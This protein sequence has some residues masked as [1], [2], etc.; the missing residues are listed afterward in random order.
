MADHRSEQI[1][2]AYMAR[3]MGLTTT[4]LNV[5]RDR[6]Y[7]VSNATSSALSV[8]MGIE[9]PFDSDVSNISFQ[10]NT[11]ELITDIHCQ[12][13]SDS[14]ISAQLNL[15]RKEIYIALAIDRNLG[16][17]FAYNLRP[18]TYDRPDIQTGDK[19]IG[20]YRMRWLIDYRHSYTDPS[21]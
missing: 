11:L 5:I 19:P 13:N 12:V 9:F 2:V 16:L 6:P 18:E 8:Y 3:V 14:V 21:Q 17:S 1:M 10:D 4:G 20:L 7:P 15:I